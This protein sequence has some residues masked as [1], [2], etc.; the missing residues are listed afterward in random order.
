MAHDVHTKAAVMAA[1]LTGEAPRRV[2]EMYGVPR[3]T[4]LRWRREIPALVGMD[5]MDL[6]K[7]L[8]AGRY[9]V[10][11]RRLWEIGG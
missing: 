6:K 8:T 1:L 2:A 4:V 9:S 11:V 5:K 7:E 3:T 10:N